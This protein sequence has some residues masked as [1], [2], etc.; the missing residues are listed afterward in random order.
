MSH[1]I[2]SDSI[3][4]S[5][6]ISK[7]TNLSLSIQTKLVNKLRENF[8]EEEQRWYV[9]NFYMYIN[10][11]QTN[12]FPIN[13]DD[14]F[15]LLGFSH[16]K[17][18]KRTLE[19]NFKK[20]QD[21][22]IQLLRTEK[23]VKDNKN[24]G[25]SGMNE[26]T[27]TMNIDTFKTLCMLVKTEQGK[28]V[29]KYYVKLEN[30]YNEVIKEE[31][32][33]KQKLLEEQKKQLDEKNKE[34][35]DV[36][37]EL[38]II[39]EKTYEEIKKDKHVYIVRT[40]G[41]DKVGKTGNTIK[42][43]VQGLQTGNVENIDIIL[44][45]ETSNEDLLEKIV[46]YIL[47][48]YRRNNREF[49]ECDLEYIKKIVILS[50]IFLDTLKSSFQSITYIELFEKLIEKINDKLNINFLEELHK[51]PIIKLRNPKELDI[52]T[53]DNWLNMNIISCVTKDKKVD[54]TDSGIKLSDIISVYNNKKIHKYDS[55]TSSLYK[56]P[57][58]KWLSKRFPGIINT[59]RLVKDENGEYKG[60]IGVCFK[61]EVEKSFRHLLDND[62]KLHIET[63][64]EFSQW[65]N[66][67]IEFTSD[68]TYIK[69]IDIIYKYKNDNT[70]NKY[71]STIMSTYKNQF[72]KWIT[73][74]HPTIRHTQHSIKIEDKTY[75]GWENL[76]FKD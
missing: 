47:D 38:Q 58:E 67:N 45:C 66:D 10:Y 52:P 48:R 31:M 6:L 7:N 60:Y 65:L 39:K 23:L 72:I 57:F 28:N 69:L 63:D 70:I 33:E 37:I 36:T 41:G 74:N 34:L 5:E 68:K 26:E 49:F 15:K 22:K 56:I 27:I 29:R 20:D 76:K 21:Y 53:F 46:H 19:N 13:L 11:H 62:N 17:N 64:E 24:L 16:K 43:R 30:V 3:N 40:D 54:R 73:I 32:E 71:N 59:Q 1:L 44:D 55:Q 18:L 9:G 61:K 75:K 42:K 8:N 12:Q 50:E 35:L 51:N 25:G 4:F 2:K 14:I